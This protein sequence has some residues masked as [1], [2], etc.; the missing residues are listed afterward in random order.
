MKDWVECESCLTEF[1]VVSDS[2][3]VIAF[4]PFCGS[5]IECQDDDEEEEFE[6]DHDY[7]DE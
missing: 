6:E 7:D 3:E 2:D 1:R 5:E 4:C